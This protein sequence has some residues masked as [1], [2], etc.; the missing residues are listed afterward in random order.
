MNSASTDFAFTL[1]RGYV[2]GEGRMHREGTMRL[3]TAIDEVAP[4][5]DARVQSN[6][7]YLAVILLSRVVSRLGR[8]PQV[9]P[10][11]IEALPV[12]DF[13][14]LQEMYRRVNQQ[15]HNRV[16]VGCPECAHRFE[17]E[18]QPTGEP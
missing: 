18:V 15:G 8:L 12:A 7:A 1:P 14:Y 9:Y 4:L 11:V 6:P 5:K 3:A 10:S 17:V 13:V 16:A 2:D